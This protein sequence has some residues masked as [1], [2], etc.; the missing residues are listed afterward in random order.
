MVLAMQDRREV[1]NLSSRNASK[2]AT[3]SLLICSTGKKKGREGRTLVVW[4]RKGKQPEWLDWRGRRG[5]VLYFGP[6]T[7]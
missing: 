3:C 1:A 7:C 4:W 2:V 5:P 6:C